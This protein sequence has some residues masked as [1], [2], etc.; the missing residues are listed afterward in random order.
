MANLSHSG[1]L[2]I[3][4]PLARRTAFT[5]AGATG[6]V[7]SSP[8]LFAPC[9]PYGSWLLTMSTYVRGMSPICGMR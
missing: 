2:L 1:R 4:M 6:T 8:T 7:A 9:G 5:M 3:S